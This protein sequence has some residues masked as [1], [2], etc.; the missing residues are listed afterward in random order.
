MK[1]E[2]IFIKVYQIVKSIPAGNVSTY[3]QIAMLMN[4]RQC[5]RMVGQALY[6]A[7]DDLTLPCHRV[8]N[9]KGR[10]VPHWTEQKE[11]LLGEGITFKSTDCVDLSKHLW[12]IFWQ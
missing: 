1:K 7:P 9:S 5:S 10:L 4:M 12:Q 2:E 6:H 11:L 8:V 3:G